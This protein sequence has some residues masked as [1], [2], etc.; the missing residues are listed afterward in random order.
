MQISLEKT[1]LRGVRSSSLTW[2]Y[3]NPKKTTRARGTK[4]LRETSFQ[5]KPTEGPKGYAAQFINTADNGT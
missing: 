2:K 1:E 4:L 3:F 5:Y